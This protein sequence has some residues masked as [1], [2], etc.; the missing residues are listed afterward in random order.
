MKVHQEVLVFHGENN[1]INVLKRIFQDSFNSLNKN[2]KYLI[3]SEINQIYCGKLSIS[4]PYTNH[5]N[6]TKLADEV[7]ACLVSVHVSI[8]AA[9][10]SFSPYPSFRKAEGLTN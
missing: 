10:Y 7:L 1:I 8:V 5:S 4:Q 9:S 2:Y 3:G 6:L